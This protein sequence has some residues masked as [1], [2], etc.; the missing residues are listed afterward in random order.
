MRSL[1]VKMKKIL[2]NDKLRLRAP[3]PEDLDYLYKW[4]NDTSLWEFG[5]T[6]TPYSRFALKQYLIDSKQDLYTDKQLRLMIVIKESNEVVGTVDLYD[7]DPF[8]KRAGVGILIDN[9]FREKGYGLQ[10]LQILE[11][12]AFNFLKLKQLYAVIP[13]SNRGSVKLFRKAGYSDAGKL[14]EW[15]STGNRYEDA[16][17]MQ[18]INSVLI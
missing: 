4:E 7:F 11:D 12:Y 9:K 13:E 18:K 16:L 10:T 14:L 3:E 2:E 15:L 6:V 5:A 8:H 1:K 17:I